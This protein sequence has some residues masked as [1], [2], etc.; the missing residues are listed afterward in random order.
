MMV[1]GQVQRA[2][3]RLKSIDILGQILAYQAI[4]VLV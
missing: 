4:E 1:R 2:A 3:C